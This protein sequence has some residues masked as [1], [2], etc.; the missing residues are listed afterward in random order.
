MTEQTTIIDII[1]HGEPVGGSKYR[2]QIDHPLSEKGWRQMR[3]AVAGRDEWQHIVSSDLRRCA[4]FAHEL[5]A[6]LSVD[7]ELVT[8]FREV[9]FGS[10]EGKSASDLLAEDPEGTAAFW[11]D[12]INN[13]PPG[14]EPLRDFHRRVVA[15]WEDLL[16]RHAGKRL[17]LVGHAGM[18]RILLLHALELPLEGFYRFDPRNAGIVRI[19]VD[20][21]RYG[22]AY[23]Q[24]VFTGPEG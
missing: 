18:M 9:G 22:E 11:R 8:G 17:L 13:T 23:H 12:P 6:K 10:W 4:D 3:S 7:V 5:G 1:R 15:S 20:S 16:R 24:L 14:A 19:R 2:G 21:G